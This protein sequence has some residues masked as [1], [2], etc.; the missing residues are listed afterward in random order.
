MIS[1]DAEES[2]L[3]S[4]NKFRSED[5]SFDIVPDKVRTVVLFLNDNDRCLV[6]PII[7]QIQLPEL[8]I[9]YIT[10]T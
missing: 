4:N 7:T 10:S 1:S 8:N 5:D 3:R 9:V 2:E 6:L